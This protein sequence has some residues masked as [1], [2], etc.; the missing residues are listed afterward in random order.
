MFCGAV[1]VRP[2]MW[3]RYPDALFSLTVPP[4]LVYAPE[5]SD[6]PS[7]V[8]YRRAERVVPLDTGSYTVFQ[9]KWVL[10]DNSDRDIDCLFL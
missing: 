7:F 4:V 9:S 6:I 2:R 1:F 10:S 8:F 5:I 3:G